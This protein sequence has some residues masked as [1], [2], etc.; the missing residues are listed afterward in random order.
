MQAFRSLLSFVLLPPVLVVATLLAPAPAS[1]TT[2]GSGTAKTEQRSVGDF[3]AIGVAGSMSLEVRQTGRTAVTITGDDNVLPLI[4][5]VVEDGRSGRTLQIRTRRGESYRS[6]QPVKVVVEVAQLT[7]LA[8]AGSSNG[9]VGALKTP[10]LRVGLSGAGDLRIEG[11]ATDEFEARLAGSSDVMASGKAK[12]V[13]L[14]VAGSGEA[15]LADLVADEVSIS[16]AGSGD[17]AVHADKS[18]SVKIAGSGDVRYRGAVTEVSK[19]VAGSGDV[20][21]F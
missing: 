7:S 5:T 6:K 13:K 18:L 14:S 15:R 2:V 9:V 16:I 21:R 8:L 11:L 12:S 19:K 1:A 20:R 10:R 17:V 3:E 4:E